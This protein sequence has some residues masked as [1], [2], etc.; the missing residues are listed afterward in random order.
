MIFGIP[1]DEHLGVRDASHLSDVTGLGCL[2]LEHR[3]FLC[4]RALDLDVWGRM[5]RRYIQVG[6]QKRCFPCKS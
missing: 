1:K 4:I 5:A 3:N 2:V 6:Q